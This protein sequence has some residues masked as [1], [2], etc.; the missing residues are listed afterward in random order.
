MGSE[1]EHQRMRHRCYSTKIV[2]KGCFIGQ[3]GG[4]TIKREKDERTLKMAERQQ[5]EIILYLGW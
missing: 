1:Q 4:R 3:H 5:E 2:G